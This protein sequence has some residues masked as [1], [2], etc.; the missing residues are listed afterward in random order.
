MG[1]SR[2]K[3]SSCLPHL[4]L[5]LARRPHADGPHGFLLGFHQRHAVHP[6]LSVSALAATKKGSCQQVSLESQVSCFVMISL[7][8][9]CCR[10]AYFICR[11][12]PPAPWKSSGAC[13]FE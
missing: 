8:C 3:D 4:H 10:R 7:C 5:P 13:F 11:C 9:T 2:A 12:C 1:A 6:A